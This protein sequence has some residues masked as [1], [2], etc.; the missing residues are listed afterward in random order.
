MIWVVGERR[1]SQRARP[2]IIGMYLA[3]AT[4]LLVLATLQ[5]ARGKIDILLAVDVVL[6]VLCLWGA[7]NWWRA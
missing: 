1:T 7:R 4:W 5:V 6:I 2:W 3:L